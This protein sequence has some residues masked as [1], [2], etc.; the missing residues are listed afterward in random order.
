MARAKLKVSHVCRLGELAKTEAL[1]PLLKL[2]LKNGAMREQLLMAARSTW[3]CHATRSPTVVIST[4]N[5]IVAWGYADSVSGLLCVYVKQ[6]WRKKGLGT[7]IVKKLKKHAR[8]SIP[9]NYA[10]KR[11]YDKCGIPRMRVHGFFTAD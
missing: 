11:F 1:K 3:R 9:W 7:T 5:G 4:E 2:C 10:G 8:Y 6:Y